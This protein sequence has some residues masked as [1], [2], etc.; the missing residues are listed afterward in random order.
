ML[1][2]RLRHHQGCSETPKCAYVIYGQPL[3]V[4]VYN[5]EWWVAWAPG[6]LGLASTETLEK[7]GGSAWQYVA[8][9]PSAR[10]G[11]SGVGLDNGRFMVTCKCWTI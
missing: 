11:V 2:K 8:S 5:S 7:D 10:Q 6:P 3:I 1:T 4:Q 9:L